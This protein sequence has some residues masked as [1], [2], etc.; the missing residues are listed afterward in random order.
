MGK[1]HIVCIR[2]V[3][4]LHKMCVESRSF[5]PTISLRSC[6]VQHTTCSHSVAIHSIFNIQEF[7]NAI[8]ILHCIVSKWILHGKV[9]TV[10]IPCVL[11][12][13]KMRIESRL[14][15]PTIS[16]RSCHVQHSTCNHNAAGH[17]I[18]N[19]QEFQNAFSTLHC[20][21]SKLIFHGK[22]GYSV[23]WVC[24]LALHKMRVE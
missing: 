10:C 24:V 2:C 9:G 23:H 12:L 11:T 22:S 20:T 15:Y 17:T 8:S 5:Y 7:Q 4:A 16:Q 18:F 13:H 1:V 14:F 3:L 21:V 6:H 19:I